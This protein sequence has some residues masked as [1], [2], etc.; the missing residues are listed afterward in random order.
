MKLLQ[1]IGFAILSVLSL[2]NAYA[3]IG[4]DYYVAYGYLLVSFLLW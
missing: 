4:T 2:G 3:L 1:T